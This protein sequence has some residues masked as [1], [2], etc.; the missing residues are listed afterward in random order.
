MNLPN[1]PGGPDKL[2]V[3]FNIEQSHQ[4]YRKY[5]SPSYTYNQFAY[6]GSREQRGL[7]AHF[8]LE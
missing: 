2:L 1:V 4:S 7:L 5:R 3:Y 8:M 6:E